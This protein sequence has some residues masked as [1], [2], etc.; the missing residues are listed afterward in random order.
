MNEQTTRRGRIRI[1]GLEEH[2]S[3]DRADGDRPDGDRPGGHR[4][5]SDRQMAA[6]NTRPSATSAY[7]GRSTLAPRDG[8]SAGTVHSRSR[9]EES[10]RRFRSNRTALFGLAIV[11]VLSAVAIVARPVEFSTMGYTI[12]LQPFSLAPYDPNELYVGPPNA[13]PSIAHPFGTDWAGRDLFSRV[14]VGGRYSLSIGALAVALALCVGIPLG[15]I[16]GYVGGWL[17]EV[18]M[19]IVDMLYAFPFLVLAIAIVAIVGQGYWNVVFA[20]VVTGWLTYAR[21]LRGEVLSIV[22]TDYVAASRALG[23]PH[24]TI[25][26]RHVVPNAVAPVIVQATLNVGSV[27]T[28]AAALGFLG[29]GLEPGTAEWGAMLA[30][31]RS[32]LLRGNWHVTVFPG[33]AI[34]LFVLAINL[35]GDGLTDALGSRHGRERRGR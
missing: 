16:A 35:V 8:T 9:L 5:A 17:D 31:G 30:Q 33:A 2:L 27:V 19:R 32:S 15:A 11:A 14:L 6:A 4:D 23:T 34:F 24:R 28:A 12:T 22:E 20:L 1:D 29:L 25:L 26:A 18:I 10:W 3:S 13:G 7:T 21:L